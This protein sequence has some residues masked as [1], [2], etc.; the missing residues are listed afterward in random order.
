MRGEIEKHPLSIING[1]YYRFILNN[2]H[3]AIM[4][5][6]KNYQIVDLNDASCEL[7]ESSRR[8]MI[9]QRC[10]KVL[11]GFDEPCFLKDLDCPVHNVFETGQPAKAV[12]RHKMPSD[13]LIWLEI[14]ASPLRGEDGSVE[15]VVEAYRN[16]TDL[17]KVHDHLQATLSGVISSLATVVEMR[18]PYT[19]GHQRRVSQLA[20]AIAKELGFSRNRFA[21]IRIAGLLHDLGKISIPLEI[22]SRPGK[23]SEEEYNL[24]KRHPQTGYEILQDIDFEWP[25]ADII[26]QHHEKWNGS[27]YPRG[28]SGENIILESRILCIADVVEAM[29]FHRPYRPAHDITEALDEISRNKSILFDAALVDICVKIFTEKGFKFK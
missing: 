13:R 27:G 1:D 15:Y 11:R 8:K 28:L 25:V 24:I 4:V 16:I 14:L 9:G 3:D 10:Y 21:G 5:I 29:L 12:H 2:I 7:C 26:L 20:S 22:L 19:A 17:V 23:I 18:D 6:D